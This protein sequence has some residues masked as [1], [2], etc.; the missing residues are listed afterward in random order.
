MRF[1]QAAF[2]LVIA[3]TKVSQM[4]TN[5]RFRV[6]AEGYE[7]HKDPLNIGAQR[8]LKRILMEITN[9]HE[10]IRS[11]QFVHVFIADPPAQGARNEA[12]EFQE[13][14]VCYGFF[15]NVKRGNIAAHRSQTTIK[16]DI[17]G[18]QNN[19][20]SQHYDTKE[21]KTAT[22]NPLTCYDRLNNK[23]NSRYD[24]QV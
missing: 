21:P 11:R 12:T 10:I 17:D 3:G 19:N 22:F 7:G 2:G 6:M 9:Q 15:R 24:R 16:V 20:R 5:F 23:A 4:K 8:H 14:S 13:H 1:E 18:S